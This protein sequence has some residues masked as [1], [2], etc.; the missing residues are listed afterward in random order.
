MIKKSKLSVSIHDVEFAKDF[1]YFITLHYEGAK[2]LAPASR[3]KLTFLP[4]HAVPSS[5]TILSFSISPPIT[6]SEE[7]LSYFILK[8][9]HCAYDP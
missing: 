8:L 1:E 7:A 5:R 4:S 3:N 9:V 2:V 6:H